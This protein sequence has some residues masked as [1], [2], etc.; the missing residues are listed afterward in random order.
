[1][2]Y[3]TQMLSIPTPKNHQELRLAN[4]QLSQTCL[5]DL[6]FSLVENKFLKK[7]GF[8]HVNLGHTRNFLQFANLV[9]KNDSLIELDLAWAGL[10]IKKLKIL[11]EKLA[12]NTTLQNLNLA[13]N[14]ME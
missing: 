13:Y 14:V 1:M 11:W 6:I 5:G 12:V 8:T 4:L 7:L 3:L 10:D 2:P 9:E